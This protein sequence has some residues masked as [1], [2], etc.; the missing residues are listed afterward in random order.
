MLHLGGGWEQAL[1]MIFIVLGLGLIVSKLSEKPRIP[2][3]AAY[4]VLGIVLGPSVFHIVDAPSQS[5]ANQFIVYLGAT[6]ILF[7]GGRAVRFDV[8]RRV[9]VSISLLVTTGVLISALIVG[10]AVHYFLHTPWVWSLLLASIMASTDPATLI[11]VFRRV[12]IVERLQQTMETESAFNDATASVL[13]LMLMTAVQTG[14]GLSIGSAVLKF[15]HDAFIGLAV[16]VVFGLLAMLLVSRKAWGI[17]HELG[18]VVM[19]VCAI[20]AYVVASRLDASGFMAAFAAGVMTGNGRSLRWPLAG[21]TEGH[22]E[23][24]GG[25]LTLM[26]RILIFVMLGTQVNFQVVY[27]HLWVGL[28]IVVVLMFVARPATV[29][30]SVLFD[31]VAKWN[32]REMIFM[33][34]VRETGVIPA[35][36]AGTAVAKGIPQAQTILAVTFLAILCTILIQATSTGAVAKRLGLARQEEQEDL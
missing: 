6:L 17:L 30:G 11:P 33:T 31:R 35:A 19:F 10:V 32:G 20:G 3:V 28:L 5:Q 16:G 21:E 22:I 36:L 8:L 34:W 18:S 7:D 27:A 9:Y 12:P 14:G 25:V 4:L 1:M 15:F 2:D 23:H 29:F 13:V 26:L 24:T